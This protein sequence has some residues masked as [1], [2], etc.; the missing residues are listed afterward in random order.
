MKNE[1]KEVL[2]GV[3]KIGKKVLGLTDGRGRSL[4][5]EN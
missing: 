5:K 3:R 2:V 4:R 1:K